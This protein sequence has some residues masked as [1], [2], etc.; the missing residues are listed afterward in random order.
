MTRRQFTFWIGIVLFWISRRLQAEVIDEAAATLMEW[1][2]PAPRS[3]E[4]KLERWRPNANLQWQWYERQTRVNGAWKLSGVTTPVN[5]KSLVAFTGRTGYLDESLVPKSVRKSTEAMRRK[6]A[7]GEV[8]AAPEFGHGQ[9]P[10][11]WLRSLNAGEIR[12]W[13]RTIRVPEVGVEG[14]TFWTH[15]TRDHSFSAQRI[16]GLTL[17]EQAK[18]HAAAHYGY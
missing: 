12:L 5:R 15:L 18:L 8:S 17:R 1:S 11:R 14:M 4:S 2:E 10:S 3:G 13:L 9:P 6:L 7:A 16:Q